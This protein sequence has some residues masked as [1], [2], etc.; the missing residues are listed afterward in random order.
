MVVFAGGEFLYRALVEFT[1]EMLGME[2]KGCGQGGPAYYCLTGPVFHIAGNENLPA[3][4][5]FSRTIRSS[6]A[7]LA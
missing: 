4:G 1:A 7:R 6:P 3:K 5:V 2:M